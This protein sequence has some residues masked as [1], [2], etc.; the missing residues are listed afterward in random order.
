MS[1]TDYVILKQNISVKFR[2]LILCVVFIFVVVIML[3]YF[4]MIIDRFIKY[5]NI[6]LF[7]VIIIIGINTYLTVYHILSQYLF[8]Y[9]IC[10]TTHM[11][12]FHTLNLQIFIQDLVG[13]SSVSLLLSNIIFIICNYGHND[14]QSGGMFFAHI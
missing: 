8:L 7:P 11:P 3:Y 9:F 12:M 14:I 2:K 4:V 5:L 13:Y 10:Q 1:K 6:S